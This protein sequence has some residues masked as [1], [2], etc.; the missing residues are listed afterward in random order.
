MERDG[1]RERRE[2]KSDLAENIYI[3]IYM[4]VKEEESTCIP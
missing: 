3:Y 2:E 4:Y 1:E